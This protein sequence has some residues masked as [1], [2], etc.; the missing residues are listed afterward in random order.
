MKKI[1]MVLEDSYKPIDEFNK[2]TNH[3]HVHGYD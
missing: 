1:D 2:N 3:D